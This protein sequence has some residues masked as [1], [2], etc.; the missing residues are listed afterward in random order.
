MANDN[1]LV[2]APNANTDTTNAKS[3]VEQLK[4]KFNTKGGG[5]PTIAQISVKSVE[6]PLKIIYKLLESM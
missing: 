5:S 2:Y 1:L 6:N 4:A 3:I